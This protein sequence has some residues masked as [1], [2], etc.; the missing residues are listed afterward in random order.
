MKY[1][2]WCAAALAAVAV[3]L[4]TNAP[5]AEG[6]W[7][8]GVKGNVNGSKL[9]GDQVGFWVSQPGLDVSGTVGDSKIGYGV[10]AYARMYTSDVFALQLEAWYYQKG[11]EGNVFGVIEVETGANTTM[12]GD[13]EGKLTVHLDYVEVPLLAVFVFPADEDGKG[14]EDAEND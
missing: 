11:G 13:V 9:R 7:E 3:V 10:G 6:K 5:R 12:P 8:V 1:H 2:R 4:V 14:D